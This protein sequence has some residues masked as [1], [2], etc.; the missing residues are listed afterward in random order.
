[1]TSETG[2]CPAGS[3]PELIANHKEEGETVDLP[4]GEIKLY[5]VGSG[6]K[7][8]LHYYDIFGMNGGRYD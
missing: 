3:L 8:V 6:D 1:M 2:C 7:V 5:I 4:G